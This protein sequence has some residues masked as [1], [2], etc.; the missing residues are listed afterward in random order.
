MNAKRGT[1]YGLVKVRLYRP[2]DVKRFN[3][4]LPASVKR[5]AVLDRTKEPG[6]IGEPLFA[7]LQL[8]LQEK[9]SELSADVMV[10]LLKNLLH[11]WFLLF[12]NTLK[13]TD[14]TDLQLVSKMDVT[15]KS[16]KIEEHIVTEPEGTT[17]CM[18]WGL[19]LT[20]QLVLTKLNQNYRSIYKQR[21]SSILCL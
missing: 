11:Q 6:S 7:T 9:I 5:I 12:T 2:F 8:L 17:N 20:V 14:S 18:F 4:A 15:H 16:L 13:T 19:V 1:K 3:E 21:C 10:Y